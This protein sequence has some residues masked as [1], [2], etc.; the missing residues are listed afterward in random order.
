MSNGLQAM[1]CALDIYK[2]VVMGLIGFDQFLDG[3]KTSHDWP[4]ERAC[5]ESLVGIVDLRA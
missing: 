4:S 2:P 1:F 3:E 5:I